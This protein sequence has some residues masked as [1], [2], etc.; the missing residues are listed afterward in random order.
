MANTD[1]VEG[2]WVAESGACNGMGF[3]PR[4]ARVK[5]IYEDGSLDLVLHSHTGERIGRE[6]P[7]MGGP[8]SFEPYCCADNWEP[9]EKPNFAKLIQHRNGY[10]YH[11][12][13]KR[14]HPEYA[15][16]VAA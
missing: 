12:T 14:P 11:L 2:G 15:L 16:G 10:G 7:A 8:T 3:R 6:S 9:I 4:V 5:H 13:W 1:F